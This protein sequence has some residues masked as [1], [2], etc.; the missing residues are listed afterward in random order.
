MI[1]DLN[2][3]VQY[4]AA[5]YFTICIDSI[6]T[7]RF[8]SP[9]YYRLVVKTI[10]MYEFKQSKNI[11]QKLYNQIKCVA[12][13]IRDKSMKRGV[14]MLMLCISIMLFAAFEQKDNDYAHILYSYLLV[15]YI[16]IFINSK[17]LFK[18]WLRLLLS[19]MFP[20]IL[21]FMGELFEQ[22]LTNFCFDNTSSPIWC[23]S[24]CNFLHLVIIN[25]P[26]LI[27]CIIL[28][29]PI[30]YQVFINWLYSHA[31]LKHIHYNLNEEYV[32]YDHALQAMRTGDNNM[33]DSVYNA[34]FAKAY[35][36]N[37]GQ[38]TVITEFN[39]IVVE[40]IMIACCSLD[41]WEIISSYWKNRKKILSNTYINKTHV[42]S[43]ETIPKLSDI[44]EDEL[45]KA[46]TKF[47]SEKNKYTIKEFC[48]RNGI[49]EKQFRE[50]RNRNIALKS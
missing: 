33:V 16:V 3:F 28:I 1:S 25:N 18:N 45:N 37:N 4:F 24:F 12:N 29:I 7:K 17:L 22:K 44:S 20:I 30:I 2:T 49:P 8:W 27:T 48:K 6:V 21:Y 39:E 32:K 26:K 23:K 31:Y 35:F 13:S 19:F 36:A 5:L 46:I 47:E 43:N 41:E 34:F 11:R 10:E 42:N 15:I 40:R 50:Q 38:D 14:F 9:D